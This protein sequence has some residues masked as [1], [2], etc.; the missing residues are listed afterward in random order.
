MWLDDIVEED[1][2]DGDRGVRVFQWDELGVLEEAVDH[3]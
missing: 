2:G 3:G 1:F